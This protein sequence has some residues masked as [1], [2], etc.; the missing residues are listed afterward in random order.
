MGSWMVG[1]DTGGT[2]T[3]LV[4]FNRDTCEIQLAKVPSYPPDPSQAVLAGIQELIAR[5]IPASEISFFAHGTT[6]GTNA[7]LEYDG[8]VTGL[9]IT[10]GFRATYEAQGWI[11]PSGSDL[12]DPGYQKPAMLVPQSLT[13]EVMGRLDYRGTEIVP[14]DEAALRRS[15]RA[16]KAKGVEAIA[17]CFLF[18]FL[19]PEHEKRA[20]AIIAE[21]APDV[22]ISLSSEVLPVIREYPRLST[23]VID[24]YVGPKV[25]GYLQ[26]LDAQLS[27]MGVSTPQ[28]FLMQS[29]GG[30]MRITVAARHPNQTLLSGPAAGVVAA[31]ELARAANCR[32]VLTFDM[33]GTSADIGVIVG[34]QILESSENRIASHDIATPMLEIRTLG[35]GGGTI[36]EIGKDGLLK[37]GPESSGSMPG[38]V[39]YGRGGTQPTVTDANLVLGSLS[40]GSPLAGSLRLDEAASRAAIEKELAAPLGLDVLEAASGIIRIV[41]THMAVDLRNALRE[42][43]QDARQFTL[44]PFGGAGPLHACYLARAVGISTVLVPLYPGINCATGLLQTTVRHSYLRSAIGALGQFPAGQMNEMFDQLESHAHAEAADEGFDAGSVKLT[45]QVELRYPHQG[46]TLSVECPARAIAEADKPQVRAAFDALH[47]RIYGQ[48]SDEDPELV[49][50]R[51]TSEIA[52]PTLRTPAIASGD[53]DPRAALTGERQLYDVDLK[54]HFTAKIHDRTLLRAGDVIEGPAIIDQ[55]DSTTVVLAD[56]QATVESA[57]TLSIKRRQA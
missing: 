14:I 15:V 9:L 55:Y 50:F 37:V 8:A 23:T 19:N 38:P 18:S 28:K 2:F 5:G 45:R 29:N 52:V 20:A 16:L 4:A 36:A 41:N 6:V 34:G 51:V 12:V 44:M 27:S 43:G 40:P 11:Q 39:C 32:Y 33:G 1:V 47:K 53:G 56:F 31:T 54:R 48:S 22:R 24:A 21:E 17:V 46:Y 30:L 49:T 13:E 10:R 3:D 35:A 25:E 57:G 7:V 26:R 42:Q